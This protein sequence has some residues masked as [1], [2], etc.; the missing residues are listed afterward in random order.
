MLQINNIST[1]GF[2]LLRWSELRSDLGTRMAKLTY[3]QRWSTRECPHLRS[4]SELYG[5]LQIIFSLVVVVGQNPILL[6]T[7]F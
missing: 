1:A 3:A 6:R 5:V 4:T 7:I 2:S